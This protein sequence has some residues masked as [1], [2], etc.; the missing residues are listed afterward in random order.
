MSLP[1]ELAVLSNFAANSVAPETGLEISDRL[2]QIVKAAL[3]RFR[4]RDSC[5]SQATHVKF[6]G[7]DGRGKAS[8]GNFEP[9][10]RSR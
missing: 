3:G 2:R 10:S 6:A 1:C 4:S 9:S 5:K 8:P 7:R